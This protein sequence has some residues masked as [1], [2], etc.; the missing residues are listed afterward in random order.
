MPSKWLS[1]SETAAAS[2]FAELRQQHEE[3]LQRCQERQQ[4][5]AQQQQQQQ[6]QQLQAAH[7]PVG[8]TRLAR[9]SLQQASGASPAYAAPGAPQ[10]WSPTT[11]DSSSTSPSVPSHHPQAYTFGLQPYNS[12]TPGG[13]AAH[14]QPPRPPAA[15]LP[16]L[17][18]PPTPYVY[19][20]LAVVQAQGSVGQWSVPAAG[21]A[22]QHLGT[23]SFDA[24]LQQQLSVRATA[25]QAFTSVAVGAGASP[26]GTA[27]V[28]PGALWTQQPQAL[29]SHVST[30]SQPTAWWTNSLHAGAPPQLQQLSLDQLQ[31]QQALAAVGRAAAPAAPQAA[32]THGLSAAT[33]ALASVRGAGQSADG[34]GAPAGANVEP[35]SI[36]DM[37][38]AIMAAQE[39]LQR[40]MLK[41]M[42]TQEA[43]PQQQQQQGSGRGGQPAANG[44]APGY[45]AAF[46]A[47]GSRPRDRAA[48]QAFLPASVDESRGKGSEDASAA[49]PSLATS[50]NRGV[51]FNSSRSLAVPMGG[52]GHAAAAPP[53]GKMGKPSPDEVLDQ[54]R[55]ESRKEKKRRKRRQRV[56]VVDMHLPYHTLADLAEEVESKTK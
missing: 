3:L 30:P 44:H 8:S 19:D 50:P 15:P 52:D 34:A 29:Q 42:S 46:A 4:Q 25:S 1:E 14:P 56:E 21:P 18:S 23:P 51:R 12:F 16:P 10:R 28:N 31:Q 47:S 49:K 38:G 2:S 26:H 33:N 55:M 43:P 36:A 5:R 9:S 20:P 37:A 41:L 39:E 45:A 22:M 40:L 11:A 17:P 27:L 32:L 7:G 13:P 35:S 54:K 24:R 6:Q 48:G 53:G